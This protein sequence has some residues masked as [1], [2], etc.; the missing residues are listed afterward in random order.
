MTEIKIKVSHDCNYYN[1]MNIT[2]IVDNHI[3]I[4]IR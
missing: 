2:L 1:V 4:E 3:I